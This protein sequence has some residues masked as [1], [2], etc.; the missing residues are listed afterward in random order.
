MALVTSILAPAPT[1]AADGRLATVVLGVLT[2]T[3]KFA[4]EPRRLRYAARDL[5]A[6]LLNAIYAQ[7]IPW[8]PVVV[9]VLRKQPWVGLASRQLTTALSVTRRQLVPSEN[10]GT[11]PPLSLET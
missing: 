4:K 8:D 10:A 6:G 11:A 1:V 7:D 9:L 5:I 3:E 2:G